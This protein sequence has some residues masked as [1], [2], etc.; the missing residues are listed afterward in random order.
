MKID[1]DVN[2]N[3]VKFGHSEFF[4]TS[5]SKFFKTSDY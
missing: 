2:E 4:R 1:P 3:T 5:E